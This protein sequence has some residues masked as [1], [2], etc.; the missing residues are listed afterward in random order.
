MYVP[1]TN[2]TLAVIH[3]KRLINEVSHSFNRW[4]LYVLV[5]AMYGILLLHLS[6]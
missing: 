2:S 1:Q 5:Y 3:V 4:H 6:I